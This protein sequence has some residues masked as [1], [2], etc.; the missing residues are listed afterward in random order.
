MVVIDPSPG[1]KWMVVTIVGMNCARYTTTYL[2]QVGHYGYNL[3]AL[4]LSVSINSD[5]LQLLV[6]A[7]R[8]CVWICEGIQIFQYSIDI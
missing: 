3:T 4:P 5:G 7:M 2:N 6:G 8:R 1:G